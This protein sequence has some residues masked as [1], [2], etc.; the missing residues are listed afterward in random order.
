MEENSVDDIAKI[1]APSLLVNENGGKQLH[2]GD[3]GSDVA[4]NHH[5]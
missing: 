5:Y 3:K 2:D 4:N 1:Q